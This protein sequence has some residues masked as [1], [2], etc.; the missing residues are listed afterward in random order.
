MYSDMMAL[1]SSIKYNLQPSKPVQNVNLN[2]MFSCFTLSLDTYILHSTLLHKSMIFISIFLFTW[3]LANYEAKM[4]FSLCCRSPQIKNKDW[5][6]VDFFDIPILG[7]PGAVG[8]R[9][10]FRCK[11]HANSDQNPVFIEVSLHL[12]I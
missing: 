11:F 4:F 3:I 6:V 9:V 1:V 12:S 7:T 5:C 10:Q 8:S 2:F